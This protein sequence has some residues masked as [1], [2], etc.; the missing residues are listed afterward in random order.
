MVGGCARPCKERAKYFLVITPLVEDPLHYYTHVVQLHEPDCI[1]FQEFSLDLGN[2]NVLVL[3]NFVTQKTSIKNDKDST[4]LELNFI[5]TT[6]FADMSA[7]K[8]KIQTSIVF[9]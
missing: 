4:P 3:N 5:L 2:K 7:L 8:K 6:N 9:S 1:A